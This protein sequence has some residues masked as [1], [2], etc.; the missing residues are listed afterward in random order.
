L[1]KQLTV[2]LLG[3]FLGLDA[4]LTLENADCLEL[5]RAAERALHASHRCHA[6]VAPGSGRS[7]R[8]TR[9]LDPGLNVPVQERFGSGERVAG[10][11]QADCPAPPRRRR[12]LD[13]P[14]ELVT[15][16]AASAMSCDC[17]RIMSDAST[18]RSHFRTFDGRCSRS[19]Y[20]GSIATCH[21]APCRVSTS[22]S[23]RAD[24]QF[25][26]LSPR[27]A[28]GALGYRRCSM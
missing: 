8:M 22:E 20:D 12:I 13:D 11:E 24:R 3:G 23:E 25:P 14:S 2:D 28:S 9:T 1:R 17:A 21:W 10:D 4:E 7:R 15:F 27:V 5:R 6:E 26:M 19:S 18:S 16:S